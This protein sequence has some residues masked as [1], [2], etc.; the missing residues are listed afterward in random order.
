M[1]NTADHPDVHAGA[2]AQSYTNYFADALVAEAKSDARIVGIHAAMGGGT[3][4]NRFEKASP[5]DA[6]SFLGILASS[7]GAHCRFSP[8]VSM[9]WELPNSMQLPSLLV[10]HARD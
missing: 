10:W 2:Q 5:H 3:G 7:A 8:T 1:V 6:F 9:M 4:M